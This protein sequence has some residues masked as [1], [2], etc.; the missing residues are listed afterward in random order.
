MHQWLTEAEG[1]K[2]NKKINFLLVCD[3]EEEVVIAGCIA[4]DYAYNEAAVST[5]GG[6]IFTE[7]VGS[8]EGA[9]L[10]LDGVVGSL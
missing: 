5:W 6:V 3:E 1:K 8:N 2:Y 4:G 9:A 7:V 10:E